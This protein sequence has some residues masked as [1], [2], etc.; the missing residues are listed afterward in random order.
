MLASKIAFKDQYVLWTF[1]SYKI[2][3]SLSTLQLEISCC[4]ALV[5]ENIY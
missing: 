3:S 5:S 2:V 1:F 4:V